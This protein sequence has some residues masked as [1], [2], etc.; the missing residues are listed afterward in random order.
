[1]MHCVIFKVMFFIF[2]S[3]FFIGLATVARVVYCQ[4]VNAHG[5]NVGQT[6]VR[7]DWPDVLP[8]GSSHSVPTGPGSATFFAHGNIKMEKPCKTGLNRHG[9][10]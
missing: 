8:T 6:L 3:M 4:A 9:E 10:M 5:E 1:M 7:G 2:F